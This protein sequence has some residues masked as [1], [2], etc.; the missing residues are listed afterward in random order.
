M[1][2]VHPSRIIV[3]GDNRIRIGSI[4]ISDVLAPISN[5]AQAQFEDVTSIGRLILSLAARRMDANL[6]QASEVLNT[7]SPELRGFLKE[8]LTTRHTIQ[9]VT[10]MIAPQ[11]LIQNEFMAK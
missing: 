11:L 10:R 9:E 3:T 7:Y 5:I 1:R 2:V 8:I 6:E 4:G